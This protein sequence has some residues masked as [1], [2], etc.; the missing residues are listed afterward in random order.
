MESAPKTG[1]AIRVR[2]RDSMGEYAFEPAAWDKGKQKWVNAGTGTEIVV[3][4]N[5]W[6][7][8]K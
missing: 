4:V 2:L 3:P 1:K 8:L 6:V 7:P 5:G